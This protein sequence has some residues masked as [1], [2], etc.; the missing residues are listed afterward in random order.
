MTMIP[1]LVAAAIVAAFPQDPQVGAKSA[2]A[3]PSIVVMPGDSWDR[4]GSSLP[5]GSVVRLA[6][7]IHRPA[8]W[9]AVQ[10]TP[11]APIVL[12]FEASSADGAGGQAGIIVG[13]EVGLELLDCRHVRVESLVVIGPTVAGI[14]LRGGESLSLRSVLLA[15]LGPDDQADGIDAEGVSDLRVQG[16]RIDGWSDAAIDLRDVRDADVR[17]LELLAMSGRRNGVGI[18]LAGRLEGVRVEDAVIRGVPVGVELDGVETVEDAAAPASPSP[19]PLGVVIRDLLLDRPAIGLEI[20]SPNGVLIERSTMVD[21]EVA[22]RLPD[23]ASPR[24]VRLVRNLVV[25]QPSRLRAF[26]EVAASARPEGI[27]WGESL[28]WSAE[29]P[30]ALAILGSIPG[31]LEVPPRHA[32]DPKIDVRGIPSET[33][34]AEFGRPTR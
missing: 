13:G 27:T 29:L 3:A 32:P 24:M 11:E 9:R 31:T 15:R 23:G 4:D 16:V 21:P 33:L 5:P 18:R 1:L 26:G 22:V 2:A 28:W 19:S 7:G 8:V 25:W 17:Q 12:R 34:A 14:R 6:P 10:G 30:T 20:R